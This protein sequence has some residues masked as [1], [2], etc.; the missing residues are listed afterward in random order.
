LKV[1]IAP[2]IP[3]M[4]TA[5]SFAFTVWDIAAFIIIII[6]IRKQA[7]RGLIN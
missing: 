3:R 4:N 7:E 5:F 6:I 2:N 1:G